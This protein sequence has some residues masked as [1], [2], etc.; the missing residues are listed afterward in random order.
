MTVQSLD[1]GSS[2][3]TDMTAPR[4]VVLVVSVHVIHQ[5]SEAPTLFLTQLTDAELLAILSDFSLCSFAHFSFWLR[6]FWFFFFR[7]YF[8]YHSFF[9]ILTQ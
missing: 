5:P 7:Q 9:R 4:S 6:L 8:T 2:S 1:E 3:T